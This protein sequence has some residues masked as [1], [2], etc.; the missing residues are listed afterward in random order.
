MKVTAFIDLSIPIGPDT[1]VYPGDPRPRLAVHSTIVRD[2]FN[3]LDV[4]M[5]SQTGTHVD[6]PYHFED[7]G[8]RVDELDLSLFAGP[9]VLVDVTG[10]PA[11]GR[12]GVEHLPPVRAGDVVL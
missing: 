12:I 6:A 1:V 3:L 9:A 4:T 7:D 11:R 2:G 5:G 8:A 10:L